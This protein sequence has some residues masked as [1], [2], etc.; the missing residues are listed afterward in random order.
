[1]VTHPPKKSIDHASQ[2]VNAGADGTDSFNPN[3]E[4][5]CHNHALIKNN[6][7]KMM[8][9]GMGEI[10][11][12][13][14]TMAKHL[15]QAGL[16]PSR[17]YH[18]LVRACRINDKT[19]NQGYIKNNYGLGELGKILDCTNLQKHLQQQFENDNDLQYDIETDCDGTP[20]NEEIK[21]VVPKSFF[22]IQ[23]TGPIVM[24]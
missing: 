15:E 11:D 1:M 8:F 4:C 6:V 23:S 13:L 12:E 2:A 18:N 24:V 5:V 3:S 17:I 7:E 9:P 16:P 20:E 19:F 10:S 14:D 22:T 21:M